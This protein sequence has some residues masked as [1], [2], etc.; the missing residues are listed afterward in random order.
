MGPSKIQHFTHLLVW[1]KGYT[2]ALD[3]YRITKT[4][5]N[6]EKFALVDQLR[7]ACVSITSNIAEGFGRDK[8]NDKS[9]FYTMA[10]GSV[11]EIQSQIL[12]A[13]GLGY[14]NEKIGDHLLDNCTEIVKM[15]TVLIKKVRSF[16]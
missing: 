8:P 6:D 4:F 14:V 3:I 9:H 15:T 13:K 2:L 5:P 1:Q 12:I 7:R 11:Y 10:L 16:A